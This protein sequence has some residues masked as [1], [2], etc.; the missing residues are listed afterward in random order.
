MVARG[1]KSGGRK[2]LSEAGAAIVKAVRFPPDLVED[3]E[4]MAEE[5]ARTTAEI[6]RAGCELEVRKWRKR[7]GRPSR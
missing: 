2:A 5:T 7:T 3:L 1:F 4:A 6:I